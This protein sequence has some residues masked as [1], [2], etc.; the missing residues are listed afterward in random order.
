MLAWK[1][2]YFCVL[3]EASELVWEETNPEPNLLWP[4]GSPGQ[5]SRRGQVGALEWEHS[6]PVPLLCVEEGKWALLDQAQVPPSAASCVLRRPTRCLPPSAAAPAG[7]ISACPPVS[8]LWDM[9]CWG[10]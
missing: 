10:G 1:C 4:W 5:T 7:V 3:I 2:L 9:V 6:P 8:L